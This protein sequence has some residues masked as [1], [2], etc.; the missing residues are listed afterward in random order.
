VQDVAS[1]AGEA[2]LSVL[3]NRAFATSQLF[4]PGDLQFPMRRLESGPKRVLD[5]IAEGAVWLLPIGLVWL[6]HTLGWIKVGQRFVIVNDRTLRVERLW[7][8]VDDHNWGV[9]VYAVALLTCMVILRLRKRSAFIRAI[10]WSVLSLPAIY[11]FEEMTYLIG[12]FID[13]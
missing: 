5:I 11:Y 8:W 1:N 6:S 2:R 3:P 12:K 4:A 9:P 7:H 10:A 13:W